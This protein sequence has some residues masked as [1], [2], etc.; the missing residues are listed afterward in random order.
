[1]GF[2][3]FGGATTGWAV[4]SNGM[5]STS[6]YSTSNRPFLVQI[7]GLAPQAATDDLLAQKL[8]AEGAHAENVGD[9]IRVPSFGQHR[10]RYDAADAFAQAPFPAD[11]VH[12][13]A[14]QI[15][16]GDLLGGLSAGATLDH[17][18]LELFDFRAAARETRDR[19]P[20]PIQLFAVDQQGIWPRQSIAVFVVVSKQLQMAIVDPLRSH[21]PR[22][23]SQPEIHS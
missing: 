16:V 18:A 12:H 15:R 5:P 1:M 10:D 17:F 19:A 14:Q 23:R 9:G 4:K 8:G 21:R 11:G 22:A 6:A 7:V 3:G 13:L 2:G 20:R